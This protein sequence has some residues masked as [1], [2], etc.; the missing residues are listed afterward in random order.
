MHA[1]IVVRGFEYDGFVSTSL[2]NMYAKFGE[3]EESS[4]M[5]NTM[6][7]YNQASW[8]AMISGLTSNGLHREAYD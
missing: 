1:Q 4:R 7:E 6:A 5:F 2:L 8:N 3:M